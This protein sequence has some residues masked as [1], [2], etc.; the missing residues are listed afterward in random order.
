MINH[1]SIKDFAIIK[2]LDIDLKPGLNIITGETG[3][4][5][6]IIIEAISMA[7]GSRADSDYIRTGCDKAVI[8]LAIDDDEGNDYVVRR[9]ISAQGKN[10]VKINGELASL[11]ELSH[12]CK[13]LADIHGQYDHQSLLN[14]DNHVDILDAYGGEE[15]KKVRDIT[16]ESYKNLAYISSELRNIKTKVQNAQRQKELYEYEAKEIEDAALQP[17]EDVKLAEEI[18]LMQNSEKIFSSLLEVQDLLYGGDYNATD[19]LGKALNEIDGISSY[20]DEL[21]SFLSTIS[22]AYYALSDIQGEIRNYRDSINFAPELLEEKIERS[23]YIE[24]LK[25]KYGSSVEEILAYRDKISESLDLMDD[26]D[27]QIAEL[28]NKMVLCKKAFDTASDRL[29]VLRDK[30]ALLIEKEV[31]KELKDLNFSNSLFG[32]KLSPCAASEKGTTSAEFLITTNKGEELKPLAKI[33]SGGELSRIML[34]LKR[35]TGDIDNIPTMIFDEIDAGIS[36]ATAGIVGEK[37]KSISKNHQIICITHLPQIA[38]KGDAHYR[39]EKTSD[40]VAT[41]TTVTP[42]DDDQLVEELARL[43]SGT[44]ITDAARNQAKELLKQK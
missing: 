42:L 29:N 19:F 21:K 25:R 2:E 7:L 24:K 30:T 33:A 39:I 22:D 10:T 9:E 28:E 1:I 36:G 41:Y 35:I 32:V 3:A 4:G 23:E 14:P 12:L 15:L 38:A 26:A 37:L 17:E 8:S 43:L 31:T 27:A 34:A 44:E 40:K 18:E 5:K 20:S 6:S 11:A 16:A 13:G